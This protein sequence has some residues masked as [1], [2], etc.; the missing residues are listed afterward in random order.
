MRRGNPQGE[1]GVRHCDYTGTV[2]I[3]CG[4]VIAVTILGCENLFDPGPP[5]VTGT[6]SGYFTKWIRIDS[7]GADVVLAEIDCPGSIDPNEFIIDSQDGRSFEG[8]YVFT[9]DDVG[10]VWRAGEGEVVQ[11]LVSPSG[12]R[13]ISGNVDS[14]RDNRGN[15]T[16]VV[17]FVPTNRLMSIETVPTSPKDYL[18]DLRCEDVTDRDGLEP[19]EAMRG[20]IDLSTGDVHFHGRN[21]YDCQEFFGYVEV[22]LR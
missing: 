6:Y 20:F 10:C 15:D 9:S 16:A 8:R 1:A 22:L 21:L 12:G 3:F 19:D 4:M 18:S 13:I 14:V 17:T 11:P 7:G 2:V 5:N